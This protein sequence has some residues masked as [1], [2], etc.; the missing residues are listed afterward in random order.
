[1]AKYKLTPAQKR[2]IKQQVGVARSNGAALPRKQQTWSFKKG[3]LVS[4]NKK[5]M[6][7]QGLTES[8]WGVV[9]GPYHVGSNSTGYFRVVTSTGI[10]DWHGGQM[11]R[12]QELNNESDE[13]V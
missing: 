7:Q 10:Q 13:D 3:D 11:D 6:R 5:G 4:L 12:V 1:M 2:D 8:P 9:A